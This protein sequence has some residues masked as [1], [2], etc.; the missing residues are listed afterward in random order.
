[1]VRFTEVRYVGRVIS[2]QAEV[3]GVSL[4]GEVPPMKQGAKPSPRF[5][6]ELAPIDGSLGKPASFGWGSSGDVTKLQL[7]FVNVDPG[8]Y[9]VI[10]TLAGEG[11]LQSTLVVG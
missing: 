9:Y 8:T 10:L 3:R 11:R 2:I 6:V 4:D 5:Q 1:M 7:L